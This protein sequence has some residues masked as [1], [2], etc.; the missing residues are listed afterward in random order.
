VILFFMLVWGVIACIALYIE[1]LLWDGLGELERY[2]MGTATLLSAFSGWVISVASSDLPLAWKDVIG[3]AWLIAGMGGIITWWAH[4][5]D[6][7]RL[8]QQD[9]A[10]R[11]NSTTYPPLDQDI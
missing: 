5:N 8:Q 10:Q 6:L 7:R 1:H 2:V 11:D 9:R 3:A 4:H